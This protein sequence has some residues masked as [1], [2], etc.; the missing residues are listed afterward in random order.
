MIQ[1]TIGERRRIWALRSRMIRGLAAILTDLGVS[2][3][4]ISWASVGFAVLGAAA[5]ALSAGFDA[6]ASAW[7]MGSAIVWIAARALCN[8]LDGLV[9]IE[10]NR[11]TASGRL[12][13]EFPDRL[14]DIAL[15]V[16]AGLAIWALPGGLALGGAVALLSVMTAYTRALAASCTGSDDF[17][18]P[19]GKPRRM[20]ILALGCLASAVEVVFLDTRWALY[21]SLI[22]IG[23]GCVLTIF[24]RLTHAAQ[25]LERES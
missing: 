3:N 17:R 25:V 9:A 13:N 8:V 19:M 23:A 1:A 11:A 18:G 14:S 6:P 12:F 5:L 4:A 15:F 7:L 16:G 24:D 10:G 22:V 20:G 2:P 21:G